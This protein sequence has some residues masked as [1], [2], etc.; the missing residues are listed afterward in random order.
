MDYGNRLTDYNYL[1]YVGWGE[2]NPCAKK[3]FS[4][5]TVDVISKKVSELT[6]GVDPQNRK[7][8]VPDER[9]GEV[10]DSVYQGFRPPTGDIFSRYIIPNNE[11][12]NMVQN[13]ID[14]TIELI[15]SHIRNNLEIEQYNSTLSSW[16][17]VYGDFNTHNLRQHSPIKIRERKP[18]TM[19]FHMNY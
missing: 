5:N 18:S 3:F 4:Q 6:R 8:V 15:T 17:Q 19:Q 12:G 2:Q 13:M 1:R 14:Q 7:I 16:V 9:I 10:M 11:Q